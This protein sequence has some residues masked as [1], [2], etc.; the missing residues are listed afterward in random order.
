MLTLKKRNELTIEQAGKLD[1][2]AELYWLFELQ[3][4]MAIIN[5]VEHLPIRNFKQSMKLTT[6]RGINQTTNF[7]DLPVVYE[8]ALISLG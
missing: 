7:A 1:E 6:L 3:A 2:N 5:D 8:S 4:S